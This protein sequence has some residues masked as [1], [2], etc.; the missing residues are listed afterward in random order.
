MSPITAVWCV[1]CGLDFEPIEVHDPNE[2][3]M[4]NPDE[5]ATPWWADS[6]LNSNI[7]SEEQVEVLFLA[8]Y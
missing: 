3:D 2:V 7:I 5:R 8:D 6:Y 1:V 4:E